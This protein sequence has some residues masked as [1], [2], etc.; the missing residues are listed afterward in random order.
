VADSTCEEDLNAALDATKPRTILALGTQAQGA[1]GPYAVRFTCEITAV[2]SGHWL[3][4]V[5]RLGVFDLVFVAGVIEHMAKPEAVTL[6]GRLRDLHTRRLYLLVPIGSAWSGHASVW[7]QNDLIALGMEQVKV[8][9]DADLPL[10]LYKFDLHTYKPAP[11]WFNSK[12][13]AHPEL[14]DKY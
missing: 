12:Y 1:F 3:S 4:E 5:D 10:H 7:E 14:W 6:I 9:A 2:K 11:E 8:C 13:W